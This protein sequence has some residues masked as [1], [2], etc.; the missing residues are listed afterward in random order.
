MDTLIIIAVVAFIS[1]VVFI[2]YMRRQKKREQATDEAEMTALKYGLTVPVTISPVVN[3]DAC[4]GTGNCVAVCP[5]KIV[6]GLREGQAVTIAPARCVGH[7]L[8]ERACPVDAI[9]LVFGSDQRGVDIPRIKENFETNVDGIYIVGELG[10][11]GLIWNA[12]E[13]GRQCIEGILKEKRTVPEDAYDVLIVGCGPGG[14]ACS[15]HA[16]YHGLRFVTIEKEPDP[17]GTVRSYPRKKLVMTYPLKVPGFGKVKHTEI[18]KEHLV[19]L[20]ADIIETTGLRLNLNETVQSVTLTDDKCF[21]VQTSKDTYKTKRVILAI[22]RRGIPRKLGVPGE[23]GSNVAYSLREP[24]HYEHNKITV[25]GGGDSA[26]EAA[27]A[28]ADQV[29]NEVRISYRNENFSRC[30]P[31]NVDRIQSAID[32]GQV[33][34]LLQT[35]LK[36]IT[37]STISYVDAGGELHTLQNDYVFVF[38]GGELPTKFLKDC[39]VQIETKFGAP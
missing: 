23:D 13:Q 26:V 3:L 7:G 18:V 32:A 24:E 6:L 25:V 36:E 14:L 37:D 21:K 1:L 30:K 31:A 9:Q 29:G 11:M 10:G 15:V 4:I 5:E 12:F 35:N 17:G 28:L 33:E 27:L 16:Q 38:I 39:G 20:W 2:P 34:P 19:G 8:C 22:G